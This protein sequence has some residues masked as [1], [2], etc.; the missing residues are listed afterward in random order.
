VKAVDFVLPKRSAILSKKYWALH[1]SGAALICFYSK[2]QRLQV[3]S[4]HCLTLSLNNPSRGM[5]CQ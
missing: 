5:L 3:V 2:A 1:F 4:Q